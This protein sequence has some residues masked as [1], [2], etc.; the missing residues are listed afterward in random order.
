MTNCPGCLSKPELFERLRNCLL[1]I[2]NFFEII[3]R[4]EDELRCY[5][6]DLG[7][8]RSMGKSY[9]NSFSEWKEVHDDESILDYATRLGLYLEGAALYSE[10][11]HL[12]R[13]CLKISED[14]YGPDHLEVA[15]D[16]NTLANILRATN[17]LEE[18]K[19]LMERALR[20][21]ENSL[22]ENQT[23][24]AYMLNTMALLLYETNRFNEAEPLIERVLKI[25]EKSLW[26]GSS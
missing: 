25:D 22:G 8:E 9:L 13:I 12:N 19:S 11:E 14:I 17:R 6:I 4:D 24:I 7:E 20:I 2:N 21:A 5:W 26:T 16:L 1:N 10:A 18:A 3:E 23:E 15:M